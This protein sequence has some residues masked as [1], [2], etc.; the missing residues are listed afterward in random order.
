M[1]TYT[2]KYVCMYVCIMNLGDDGDNDISLSS[3][4]NQMIH[5]LSCFMMMILLS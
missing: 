3:S 1:T 2:H 5:S 4:K